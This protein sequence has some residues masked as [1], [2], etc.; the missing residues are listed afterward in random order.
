M[1][2]EVPVA[3]PQASS[4]GIAGTS[5]AAMSLEVDNTDE[6]EFVVGLG[7]SVRQ[8]NGHK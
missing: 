5:P 4:A 3:L 6:S 7:C 2:L 1:S 8:L